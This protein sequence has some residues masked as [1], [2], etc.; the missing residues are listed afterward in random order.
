MYLDCL[1][2]IQSEGDIPLVPASIDNAPATVTMPRQS[3]LSSLLPATTTTTIP[4][5]TGMYVHISGQY[6]F[7]TV[8]IQCYKFRK[9][10]DILWYLVS[11]IAYF[12]PK[13]YRIM[14]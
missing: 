9:A 8:G 1:K 14:Y 3:L 12:I 4:S 7:A 2:V 11:K 5:N 6:H 10:F 13:A